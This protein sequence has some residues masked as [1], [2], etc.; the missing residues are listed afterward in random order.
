MKFS[1]APQPAVLFKLILIFFIFK[2]DYSADIFFKLTTFFFFFFFDCEI[3][4]YHCPV[5]VYL[6]IDLFQTW[7]DATKL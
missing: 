1:M 2:G 4:A 7:Y 5:S 3:Y 6:R